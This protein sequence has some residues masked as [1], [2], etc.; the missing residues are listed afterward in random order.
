[1]KEQVDRELPK[2]AG[3]DVSHISSLTTSEQRVIR[4]AID[5]GFIFAFRVAMLGAAGLALAAAVF[6]SAIRDRDV[7]G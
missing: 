1:V 3:A 4:T 2:I 6:G 5:S 7:N